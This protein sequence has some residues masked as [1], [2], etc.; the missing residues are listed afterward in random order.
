MA[1]SL[2]TAA[3]ALDV[4]VAQL[5][6]DLAT[7]LAA[8]GS[9]RD[10]WWWLQLMLTQTTGYETALANIIVKGASKG[11]RPSPAALNKTLAALTP[12]STYP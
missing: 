1:N 5:Q 9:A 3:H 8:G 2:G 12:G 7:Y 4:D 11:T 6:T 10:F